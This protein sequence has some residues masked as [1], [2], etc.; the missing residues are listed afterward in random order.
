MEENIKKCKYCHN[1]I[2]AN[3]IK[4]DYCGRN[5]TRNNRVII[6]IVGGTII[7]V[8]TIACMV[9]IANNIKKSIPTLNDFSNYGTSQNGT[10]VNNTNKVYKVGEEGKLGDGS[11]TVTKV[12]KTEGTTYNKAG[13]GKEFVIIT[14]EVKNN[15][16]KN[17][18]YNSFYF[19]MQN[20]Q[21]Q[22]TSMTFYTGNNDTALNSGELAPG[23]KITGTIAFEQPKGDTDL[24]LIYN[25]NVW[26]SKELKIKLQ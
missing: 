6:G 21:G 17:L 9:S 22:I 10:S 5:Q 20:G 24:T 26:S 16:N 23:G 18:A 2:N 1:E 4:C 7:G 15:G 3:C 8:V 12:D 13:E 19:K 14:V 11:V 25:D